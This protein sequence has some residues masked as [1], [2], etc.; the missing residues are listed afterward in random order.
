MDS[1]EKKTSDRVDCLLEVL[2]GIYLSEDLAKEKFKSYD[3]FRK[4]T[5]KCNQ[6][7]KDFI[8]SIRKSCEANAIKQ[9]PLSFLSLFWPT[10]WLLGCN[11]LVS[12]N[13]LLWSQ[14]VVS[15]NTQT[16]FRNYFKSLNKITTMKD[17]ES[18]HTQTWKKLLRK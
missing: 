13:I 17:P 1:V 16:W 14:S 6:N 3:L 18:W 10:N 15:W 8:D 12:T 5:R 4:L 9:M 7:V 11:V 2:D